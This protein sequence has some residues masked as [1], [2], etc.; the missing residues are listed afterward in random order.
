MKTTRLRSTGALAI[1]GDKLRIGR[2][3]VQAQHR[4][5]GMDGVMQMYGSR[6]HRR[7]LGVEKISSYAPLM[8]S[9]LLDHLLNHGL[10]VRQQQLVMRDALDGLRSLHAKRELHLDIKPENI[11]LHEERVQ[12]PASAAARTPPPT[13][14]RAKITDLGFMRPFAGANTKSCTPD[15]LSPDVAE[16]YLQGSTS[17]PRGP[18]DDVFAMGMVLYAIRNLTRPDLGGEHEKLG[19]DAF[20]RARANMPLQERLS[21]ARFAAASAGSVDEII[22]RMLSPKPADRPTA[23]DAYALLDAVSFR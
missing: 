22:A 23:A 9:D 11:L 10:P 15:Y 16:A 7:A 20:L 17:L 4:A 3:E 18:A 12:L 8:K 1:D 13:Q 14:L 6:E 2:R 5:T 21:R 19:D